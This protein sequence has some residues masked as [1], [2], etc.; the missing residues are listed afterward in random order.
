MCKCIIGENC[1]VHTIKHTKQVIFHRTKIGEYRL[2]L[3]SSG[4]KMSYAKIQRTLSIQMQFKLV[5]YTCLADVIAG[6]AKMLVF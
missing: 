5:T 2:S 3:P 1:N 4:K 6:V